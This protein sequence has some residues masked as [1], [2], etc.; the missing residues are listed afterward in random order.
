MLEVPLQTGHVFID[1]DLLPGIFKQLFVGGYSVIFFSSVS[2]ARAH[3]NNRFSP[4]TQ[5]ILYFHHTAKLLEIQGKE[6]LNFSMG[7]Q[8]A[9]LKITGPS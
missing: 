5:E 3:Q 7:S 1:A 2:I 9:R 4:L 8:P 6:A